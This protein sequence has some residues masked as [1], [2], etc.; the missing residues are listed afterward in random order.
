M[1][2]QTEAAARAALIADGFK[3]SLV[4]DC[5]TKPSFIVEQMRNTLAIC[6][7]ELNRVD[8]C[9]GEADY[10]TVKFL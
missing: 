3:E 6:R 5:F 10:Y 4:S 2:Y 1:T 7:I 8:P 9:Y